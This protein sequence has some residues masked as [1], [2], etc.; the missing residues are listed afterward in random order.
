MIRIFLLFIFFIA[1]GNFNYQIDDIIIFTLINIAFFSV[2]K[3]KKLHINDYLIFI[4]SSLVVEV[5][6]GLPLFISASLIILPI[7]LISYLM[8]NLSMLLIFHSLII[9]ILSLVAIFLLD[10]SIIIRFL[11]IQYFF[12]IIILISVYVG[13]RYRGKE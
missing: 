11:D 1:Y 8:N 9:F 10:Q 4:L 3:D 5:V 7:L 2:L 13:L 6:L 12:S